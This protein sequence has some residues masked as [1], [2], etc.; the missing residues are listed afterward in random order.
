MNKKIIINICPTGIIPTKDLNRN[1]P[2]TPDEIA[3]DVYKCY[4]LGA[5]MAHIHARDASGLNTM[6]KRVYADIIIKIRE[7]CPGIIICASLS[8]RVLNTVEARSDVLN[9][10]GNAKPD[11]GSL[12]LSSLNFSNGPSINSPEMIIALLNKMNENG[13]KPE[14]EV[15][16]VG[17]INYSKYL[18]KKSL[19]KPPYYYNIILG[20]ISSA[21][22]TPNDLAS[23]VSALPP[24]SIYSIGGIG[25]TMLGANISGILY[26]DGVRVGLEDNLYYDSDRNI[27]GTNEMFVKR[28]LDVANIYERKPY[29]CTEVRHLLDL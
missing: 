5:Q 21:Q 18:I 3:E 20:N 27:H 28:I 6:D 29:T 7:K 14:L 8:G 23:M 11:M 19:L 1:T 2:I 4:V 13:I 17:M 26:G 12:T 25:S 15:F 9:L 10:T 22:N 24:N 16:D